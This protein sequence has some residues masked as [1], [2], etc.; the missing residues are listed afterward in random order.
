MRKAKGRAI[1]VTNSEISIVLWIVSFA[2]QLIAIKY[3]WSLLLEYPGIIDFFIL[4]FLLPFSLFMSFMAVFWTNYLI[5]KYDLFLFT[6]KITNPDFI[7]WLRFTR[8]KGCRPAIVRKGPLGE[9]KG[10]AN[11]V[12]A[13]AINKGDYTV[14]LPN[15][16]QCIIVH[17]MCHTNMNLEQNEGWEMIQRHHG[18]IGFSAW[19]RAVDEGETLFDMDEIIIDDEDEIDEDQE[20][21]ETEE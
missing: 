6:D 12:K 10:V 17:D 4:I 9:V 15:G 5:S 2:I 16:N 1:G 20:S 14:T 21:E 3:V 8:S 18:L 19:E 7:G 11:G 13:S